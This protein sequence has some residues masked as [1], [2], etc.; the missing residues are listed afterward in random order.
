MQDF[1]QTVEVVKQNILSIRMST[2]R[3]GEINQQVHLSYL[4][5][6]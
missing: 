1:F 3:I 4:I 2:K 5:D 6:A